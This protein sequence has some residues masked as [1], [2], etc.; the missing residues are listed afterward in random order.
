MQLMNSNNSIANPPIRQKL[1]TIGVPIY[2]RLEYLPNVLKMVG[3]QDYP[4]IELLVSD[5]GMNGQKVQQM[6]REN[7]SRSYRVRQ[8]R[9]TVPISP[10]FNQIISEATGEYFI[11]LNDDDEIS[12][13]YVSELVAQIERHPQ[14]T[15]AMAKQEIIDKDGVVLKKSE[16]VL[17][18]VLS[19]PD[20]IRAIWKTYE[21][22]FTNVESFLTK[23][24]LLQETGGYPDFAHGNHSDDAAAIRVCINHNAVFSTKCTYRHR[25]HPGGHGWLASINDLADASR[26]FLRLLDRDP[27]LRAFA[28]SDPVQWQDL[29]EILTT[30]TWETY[31]WRWKD[32]YR[33][34]LSGLQWV[35]AAFAFG[36][37][38]SYYKRVLRIFRAAA[39]ERVKGI[40]PSEPAVRESLVDSISKSK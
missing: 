9:A 12:A 8:N 29:R 20:F 34:R 10:H 16:Q 36:F 30:M 28:V 18:P 22:G 4:S 39:K 31:L 37:I 25:V 21:F 3:S 13:D 5:N 38:P 14:A 26:E 35:R 15:L 19:G 6:V 33:N 7:Y 17:P 11:M 24:K 32:I 27:T 40:L 2:K 23:T 1:V